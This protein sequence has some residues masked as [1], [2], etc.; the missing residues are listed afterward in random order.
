MIASGP[1]GNLDAGEPG[2]VVQQRRPAPGSSAPGP[3]RSAQQLPGHTGITPP[4]D[5]S[6]A[7]RHHVLLVMSGTLT[8]AG[9]VGRIR[10]NTLDRQ[11]H[12]LDIAVMIDLV[13]VSSLDGFA[14]LV[15]EL[16]GDPTPWLPPGRPASDQPDF[17]PFERM[18]RAIEGAARA[19]DCPD[20]GRRLARRQSVD[21]LGPVG[22]AVRYSTTVEDAIQYMA[23]HM[24]A[25]TPALRTEL[26]DGDEGR[27]RYLLEIRTRGLPDTVQV[28]ELAL[29]V[30]L[31]IL[32]A[33]AGPGVR[34]LRAF[35][36]HAPCGP[37]Q[38][39]LDYFGCPVTFDADHCGFDLRTE[40]LAHR[41]STA[42]PTVGDLV[43]RYLTNDV[44]RADNDLSGRVR[45]LILEMLPTGQAHVTAIATRLGVH[46]RTLHRWL[47][48]SGDT[49]DDLLDQTRSE[50]ARHYLARSALPVG[51]IS[52][53]VG[54][55][56][57]SAFSRACKRWFLAP[58]TKLRQMWTADRRDA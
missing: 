49:F 22:V 34:P 31:S 43:D 46:P 35:L 40:D 13:R 57:Q 2:A 18:A 56:Q 14:G 38:P 16:G 45:Q 1:I 58:P 55:T 4:T 25:Y 42:D 47:A 19:L 36:P 26:I 17:I 3:E 52:T 6:T 21:I 44:E 8:T 41:R 9:R 20:F 32:K 48:R 30:S 7:A 29:G 27:R 51:T 15:Q 10:G 54:Y 5:Q 12:L 24:P 28:Y 50:R 23:R 37:V 11:G 39:Y 53:L 33:V